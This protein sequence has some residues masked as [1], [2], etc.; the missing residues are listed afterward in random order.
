MVMCHKDAGNALAKPYVIFAGVLLAAGALGAL[1]TG[2]WE[3]L[4]GGVVLCWAVRS[5]PCS[6]S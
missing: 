4:L 1:V 6:G 5:F 2:E 3:P